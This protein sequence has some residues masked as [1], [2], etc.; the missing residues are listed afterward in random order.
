M[1]WTEPEPR[2]L[3]GAPLVGDRALKYVFIDEAGTSHAEPVTIVLGVVVDADSQI[4]KAERAVSEVIQ[5]VPEEFAKDFVFHATDVW[6]SPK[7]RDR[8]SMSSR[9]AILNEMMMLPRK[10]NAAIAFSLC[11][12]SNPFNPLQFQ[13]MGLS[14]AQYHHF[15]AFSNTVCMADRYIRNFGKFD[16]VGTVVAEDVPE[17]RKFLK[18]VPKVA[19]KTPFVTRPEEI[20]MTAKERE[21]GYV[22]QEGDLRVTRIRNSVHFVEKSEDP[23]MQIADACAFGLRRYFSEQTF[24]EEFCQ[25]IVGKKYNI[26]DF[27]GHCSMILEH[28]H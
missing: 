27:S 11:K 9:K 17:M 23:I 19:R 15:L 22:T 26:S 18:L 21:L 14:L 20:I 6:G 12:R 16:E 5:A 24:G 28:F 10:L 25:S 4:M 3:F 8:W 13:Q 1:R 2:S 7:Y